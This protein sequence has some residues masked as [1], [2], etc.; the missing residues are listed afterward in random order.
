MVYIFVF[1]SLFLDW[2]FLLQ[3]MQNLYTGFPKEKLTDA[4]FGGDAFKVGWTGL[5]VNDKNWRHKKD[6][7]DRTFEL[8]G[9][10][11]LAFVF[12]NGRNQRFPIR[13]QV[14]CAKLSHYSWSLGT[15]KGSTFYVA[16]QKKDKLKL[17]KKFSDVR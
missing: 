8:R 6:S 3:I 12:G 16:F 10:G 17:K 7:I 2:R 11:T 14:K 9:C 15:V 4:I 1:S 5:I 13:M